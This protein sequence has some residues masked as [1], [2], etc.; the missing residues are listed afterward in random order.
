MLNVCSTEFNLNLVNG[1][2]ILEYLIIKCITV[3]VSLRAK[4]RRIFS[5]IIQFRTK[6]FTFSK[7]HSKNINDKFQKETV[8]FTNDGYH[9]FSKLE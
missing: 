3:L 4:E 2:E 8:S 6:K 9:S 7:E 5:L 1:R